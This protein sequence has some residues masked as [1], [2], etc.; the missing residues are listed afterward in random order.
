VSLAALPDPGSTFESFSDYRCAQASCQLTLAAGEHTL[1]A[2]FDPLRVRVLTNGTGRVL[3]TPSGID[4]NNGSGGCVASY[5]GGTQL[6]LQTSGGTPEWIAGCTPAGG[7][8]HATTCTLTVSASP[9]W[10]VLRFGNADKPG[11]PTIVGSD[12][13][14]TV[15]G[16]GTVSGD[17]IDCGGRCIAS[18]GF[19]TLEHLKATAAPGSSFTG[20]QGGCGSQ[21]DCSFPVGPITAVKATFAVEAKVLHASLLS[22]EAGGRRAKRKVSAVLKSSLA[23]KLTLRLE[24]PGGK[25]VASR[26]VAVAAGMSRASLAVPRKTPPGRYRLRLTLVAGGQSA[27]LTHLVRIGR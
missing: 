7:D 22:V 24:R 1:A 19:G 8:V 15:D 13:T 20:W 4:C 2:T 3:S 11:V 10:V 14:V 6:S 18:Y 16:Q 23:G 26:M 17:R 21:S 12:L 25:R 27:K 5:A 9:T